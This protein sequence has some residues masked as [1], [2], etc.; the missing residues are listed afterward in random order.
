MLPLHGKPSLEYI[1]NGLI[2]VGIRDFTFVVGYQK[3]QI[4][5]HFKNGEKWGVNIQYVEQN[6]LNGTGGAL[7]LCEPLIKNTHFVLTWGDNLLD[8][9]I[10]AKI[11]NLFKKE[12]HNFILVTNYSQDPHL[13]AAVYTEGDFC[14]DIIE[15][16][17]RCKSKSNLNNA[18]L[19]ILSKEIFESLK[20]LEPSERGEIE[21]PQA[22]ANGIKYKNWKVR[23]LR[24]EHDQFKGDVG[25]KS[26]YERLKDD[27]SWL[28]FL[29]FK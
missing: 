26:E 22:I 25:N 14:I 2:Y 3:E 15:K 20:A 19:F 13:G 18:G 11:I 29:K 16:P 4:I 5:G 6:N 9:D 1:L 12:V 7:L 27:D 23:V 21:L 8:Y 28:K 24:M 10:Y 17:P